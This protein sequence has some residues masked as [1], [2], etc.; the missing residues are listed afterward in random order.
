MQPNAVPTTQ[1]WMKNASLQGILPNNFA[2]TFYP[3]VEVIVVFSD[4]QIQLLLFVR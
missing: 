3:T 1:A 2:P 4:A